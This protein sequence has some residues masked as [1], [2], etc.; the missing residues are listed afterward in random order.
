MTRKRGSA[1]NSLGARKDKGK[2]REEPLTGTR[3]SPSDNPNFPADPNSKDNRNPWKRIMQ[4]Q[5]KD[6]TD[7]KIAPAMK[8]PEV[9]K[10]YAVRGFKRFVTMK[11]VRKTKSLVVTGGIPP[12]PAHA[13]VSSPAGTS[14]QAMSVQ[15]G[16]PSH[17]VVS[18]G[19]QCLPT[20]GGPSSHAS[21]SHASPSHFVTNYHTN[22]D[23]DSRSS[24]DGSCNR[25]LDKIC[26]PRG[27]Y[28]E[29]S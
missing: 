1:N 29:D 21:P 8:R 14:S 7:T 12:S 3:S 26:F 20:I 16:P 22:H 10:V 19:S 17:V 9:V 25:F 4:I 13:S 23:S 28:H 11:R 18:N 24:I 5:G 2:Q 15:V 27:H 6:P